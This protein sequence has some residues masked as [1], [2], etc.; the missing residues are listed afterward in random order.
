MRARPVCALDD[1]MSTI[2]PH[3]AAIMSG[4]A[5]CTQWNVPVRFTAIIRFHWSIVR[6]MNF[7]NVEMPAL[8]TR[9]SIGPSSLADL[10]ERVVDGGAVGDVDRGAERLR[11]AAA[12][13]GGGLLGGVDVEVEH[14]DPVPAVGEVLRRSTSPIPDAPPVTTATRLIAASP[15]RAAGGRVWPRPRGGAS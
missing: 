6:S 1:E 12:E 15:R 5:D 11:P 4:I 13:V 2:R 8:V 9:I 3:L 10:V 7:T 14:R